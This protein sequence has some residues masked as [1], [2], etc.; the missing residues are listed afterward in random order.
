MASLFTVQQLPKTS[1]EA[2]REFNERYLAV[3][4]AA[5]PLG[6]ADRFILG[7]DSPYVTFPIALM[8]TKFQ[9]TKEQTSRFKTMAEKEFDLKVVEFDAGYEAKMLDLAT[10]TFAYR[11]WTLA[12][13][14]LDI[15]KRRHVAKQLATLLEDTAQTSPWDGELFFD[16]DHKA[17]PKGAA[18]AA[19]QW[20]NLQSVAAAPTVANIQ[21]EATAM[22]GV[23]DENGDKLGVEPDEI[24]LPTEKFQGVSD[25]LNQNLINNG[26]T[27]PIYGKY[28][29]VH[30]PDLTDV[31]DWYLVDSKLITAGVDPM[32]AA[33]YLPA[34]DLGLRSW[35]ESSDFFKDTGKIKIS[36][37]IWTGFKLVFPHAIR[38]VVG[39]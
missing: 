14:R 29:A 16:T 4:S 22:R 37:H 26:E 36:Q 15:A 3:I 18:V 28:K 8:S 19:N 6:W 11:N 32:V 24:W 35:D 39:A 10:K 23:K 21:I 1:Q 5:Q 13:S 20:S 34:A 38:K 9:E 33:E 17:N 2:I 25:L 31:N 12:P 7:V 27:N 30:V